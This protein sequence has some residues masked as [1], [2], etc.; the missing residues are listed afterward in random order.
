MACEMGCAHTV[1]C[2]SEK[3]GLAQGS[4]ECVFNTSVGVSLL[5]GQVCPAVHVYTPGYTCTCKHAAV[6]KCMPVSKHTQT[7]AGGFASDT[8]GEESVCSGGDLGLILR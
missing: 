7:L 4:S 8:G 5:H 3:L 2:V 6:C 1:L